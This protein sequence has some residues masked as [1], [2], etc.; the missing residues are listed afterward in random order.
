MG[1]CVTHMEPNGKYV[2][3]LRIFFLNLVEIRKIR[4]SRKGAIYFEIEK[5]KFSFK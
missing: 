3:E 4:W 2:K 1:I 5:V